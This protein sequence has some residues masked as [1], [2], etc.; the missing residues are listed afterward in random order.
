MDFKTQTGK[1]V[2]HRPKC[3]GQFEIKLPILTKDC[4]GIASEP[5][6]CGSGY[7]GVVLTPRDQKT[8]TFWKTVLS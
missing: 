4:A 7:V 5:H 6:E 8:Y 1:D 2:Y 3:K